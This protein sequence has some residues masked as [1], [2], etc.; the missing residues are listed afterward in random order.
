MISDKK[1]SFCIDYEAFLPN[2]LMS[3]RGGHARQLQNWALCLSRN[4]HQVDIYT[5]DPHLIPRSYENVRFLDLKDKKE[6]IYDV[7]FF[8]GWSRD[9]LPCEAKLYLYTEW[10]KNWM[11][12]RPP[13]IPYLKDDRVIITYPFRSL[14][15]QFMADN[16]F[17]DKT[18]L[19][20]Y[21]LFNKYPWAE[22]LKKN[23]YGQDGWSI[24]VRHEMPE[25]KPFIDDMKLAI[26]QEGKQR[27]RT[28]HDFPVEQSY[29]AVWDL[30]PKLQ[31]LFPLCD[32][33]S[34]LEAILSGTVP[35]PIFMDNKINPAGQ[36]LREGAVNAGI[37]M[38][39]PP[40]KEILLNIV[41]YVLSSKKV[42]TKV[43]DAFRTSIQ[44][45]TFENGYKVLMD[46]LVKRGI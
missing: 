5:L 32:S 39:R 1:Y 29:E 7:A 26:V 27:N 40:S 35:L 15:E 41:D 34:S 9:D 21:P 18:V 46:I 19:L 31:L 2:G 30:M 17:L 36:V 25:G 33:A 10:S 45:N 44:E 20:P 3:C 13:Q 23:N 43:L 6:R 11:I 16:I 14:T 8:N 24:S 12:C 28:M 22:T 37:L 38:L 42:Y 4:G